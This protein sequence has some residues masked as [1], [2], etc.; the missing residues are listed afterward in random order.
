MLVSP[1]PQKEPQVGLTRVSE[2]PKENLLE[3]SAAGHLAYDLCPVKLMTNCSLSQALKVT[4]QPRK[5]YKWKKG[6]KQN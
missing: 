1:L 6:Q 2:E 5:T 4:D 3:C